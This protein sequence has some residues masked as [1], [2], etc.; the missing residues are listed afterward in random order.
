M[1]KQQ[2]LNT[3]LGIASILLWSTTIAVGRSLTEQLG[4]F[5]SASLIYLLGGTVGLLGLVAS[6]RAR[7]GLLSLPRRYLFGAGSLFALYMICLYAALGLAQT[8]EQALQVGLLNYLW[9]VLT[10]LLSIPILGARASLAIIPASVTALF[11]TYLVLLPQGT[12][13]SSFT[14]DIGRNPAPYL[15]AT[16]AAVS[17]ALYSTLSRRWA[18]N[19]QGASVPLFMLVT[20]VLLGV[21]RLFFTE[22]SSWTWDATVELVLFSISASL[23]YLFWE[24][25]MRGGNVVLVTA[26]SYATPLLSTAISSWYL[27]VQPGLHLWLGCGLI[28]VGAAASKMAI[29]D[30][31]R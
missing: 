31:I 22:T 27:G 2:P 3:L 10:L 23:A 7:Q 12:A 13:H 24:R 17:W 1:R 21:T 29:K 15:L 30:P 5:T 6:T 19:S 14:V 25:A 11:G 26:C 8:R 9:P 4:A 16:I 28:I 18:S 20:G